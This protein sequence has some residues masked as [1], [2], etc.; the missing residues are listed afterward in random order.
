M[1]ISKKDLDA[2][3]AVIRLARIYPEPTKIHNIAAAEDIPQKFLE[4]ILSI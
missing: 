1:N 3:E 4:L 2:L